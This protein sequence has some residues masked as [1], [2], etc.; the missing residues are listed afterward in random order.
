MLF[1]WSFGILLW[2]LQTRGNLPYVGYEGYEVVDFLKLGNRLPKPETCPLEAYELMLGKF[3]S[4]S[5]S[6]FIL[7]LLY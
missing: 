6:S 2:E 7:I 1:S 3:Y 4:K 5:Y